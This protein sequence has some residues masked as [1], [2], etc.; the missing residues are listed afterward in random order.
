MEPL[1][2]S[3]GCSPQHL[4]PAHGVHGLCVCVW[5][6]K[7]SVPHA[8]DIRWTTK[9]LVEGFCCFLFINFCLSSF[10]QHHSST[11]R[12]HSRKWE[13]SINELM[14]VP[15]VG[16]VHV[17]LKHHGFEWFVNVEQLDFKHE[18]R[19]GRNN[20]WDGLT[21]IAC[22]SREVR[23]TWGGVPPAPAHNKLQPLSWSYTRDGPSHTPTPHNWQPMYRAPMEW[24]GWLF[25]RGRVSAHP[26]PNLMVIN[27]HE[28]GAHSCARGDGGLQV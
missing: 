23:H 22:Q 1:L 21:A 26:F 28:T 24:L 11:L 14:G 12:R 6:V 18:G 13:R 17:L 19:V 7:R 15:A 25:D 20:V 16:A 8:Q 2:L 4:D 9:S 3:E 27:T 5:N 10:I